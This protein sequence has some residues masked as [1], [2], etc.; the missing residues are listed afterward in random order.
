MSM[1][2]VGKHSKKL[3]RSIFSY[4][5]NKGRETILVALILVGIGL[6]AL[7]SYLLIISP[8]H[9]IPFLDTS[10]KPIPGSVSEKIH[11]TING[12]K[13]GM[14]I[15]SKDTT[16]PVLLYVHGGPGMPTYFLNQKYP[17]GLDKDFTVCWWEQ[18]GVGLSYGKMFSESMTIEQFVGDVIAVSKYLRTRFKQEKIYLMGHS[19]G[20][21]IG[22][23]AAAKAP[24]LFHAYIGVAQMSDQLKS[25]NEAYNFM[26]K[27]SEQVGDLNLVKKLQNAHPSKT[28]PLPNAYLAIRDYAMHKL[29]VGTTHD[30][31][32]I[33]AGIFL[34]VWFEKEYTLKEKLNIWRGKWSSHSRRLWNEMLEIDLKSQVPKLEIPVYF[35]HGIYDYTITY[36]TALEYYKSIDAP[37]KGFYTFEKSAHSP[38]FEDPGRSRTIMTQDV[39]KGRNSLSDHFD[40]ALRE[41]DDTK[42]VSEILN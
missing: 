39:T 40:P 36:Q 22:I 2:R 30:M 5:Y 15:K 35:F 23:Q 1:N 34:P 42:H 20:S 13:Q 17:T 12:V 3:K 32:S 6:V 16:R 7:G 21:F 8:G 33:I 38:I 18:R 41:K 25:E 29:G 14:F 24:E 27:K 11:V 9:P 31:K 28:A 37:V 10:N 19:W 26:I 4:I